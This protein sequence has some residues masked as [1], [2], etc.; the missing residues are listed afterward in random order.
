MKIRIN[1][2]MCW[3]LT[4]AL[5]SCAGVSLCDMPIESDGNY[6][7]GPFILDTAS[8]KTTT[9]LLPKPQSFRVSNS[10][11]C[12]EYAF[13][14]WDQPLELWKG[15]G[16][17]EY[18]DMLWDAIQVWNDALIGFNRRPIVEV[19]QFAIGD[20]PSLPE[21]FWSDPYTTAEQ[22]GRDGR[23]VIYFK[24]DTGGN[25]LFSFAHLRPND[26]KTRMLEADI[27]INTTHEERYDAPIVETHVVFPLGDGYSMYAIS[28][29]TFTTILHELGHAL[30]LLHIPVSGN[31]M[32]YRFMPGLAEMW[33]P[34]MI[35]TSTFSW[36]F[37][38]AFHGL[39]GAGLDEFEPDYSAFPF[40]YR[41]SI[42]APRMYLRNSSMI[43]VMG[44][45][46]ATIR[47]GEQDKMALLCSYKFSNWNH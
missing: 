14:G 13:G 7:E 3:A 43:Q 15:E 4:G 38:A 29:A 34:S 6:C 32:S 44:M 36:V 45:F 42:M 47:L 31:I 21:N 37:Q 10:G 8:G 1:W 40:A 5:L 23:S 28:N 20:E 27:Y 24:P 41:D 11:L 46:D 9:P 35:S 12:S 19:R 17:E 39:A 30:G 33:E 2:H 25:R 26:T 18:T 16:A 22:N